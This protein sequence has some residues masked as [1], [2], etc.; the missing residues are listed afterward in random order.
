VQE[1][2]RDKLLVASTL[3]L[4]T[5]EAEEADHCEV[6][7]ASFV[8]IGF[9]DIQGYKMRSCLKNMTRAKPNKQNENK[10]G[11]GGARL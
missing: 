6:F 10:A 5:P 7:Q 3:H 1:L 4:S 11:R 2:L 8:Y 9:Q